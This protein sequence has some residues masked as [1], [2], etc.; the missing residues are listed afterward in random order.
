MGTAQI[1]ELCQTMAVHGRLRE[2]GR[3]LVLERTFQ[4]KGPEELSETL[5]QRRPGEELVVDRFA[6]YWLLRFIVTMPLS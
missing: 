1:V 6:T 5:S 3:A 4:A 2:N